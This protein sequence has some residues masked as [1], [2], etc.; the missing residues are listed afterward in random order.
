MILCD[1][2]GRPKNL[3]HD[4]WC[5]YSKEQI[6]EVRE[7][8]NS[9]LSSSK[10]V[11]LGFNKTLV[12]FSL[13]GIKRSLSES[14]KIAHKLYSDNFRHSEET[15][16]LLRKKTI[17]YQKCNP[18]KSTQ[19]KDRKISYP[20]RLFKQLLERN[21]LF[22]KYDIVREYS[23]FPYFIDF[24]FTNINL[25]VEIDGAQHWTDIKRIKSDEKKDN[26]LLSKN[27]RIYRIPAFLVINKIN[28]VEKTF[29]EYL[30]N[31][32]EQPKKKI[33]KNEIIEY[34]ELKKIQLET[35]QEI[36]RKRN[37]IQ[38]EIYQQ[39]KIDVNNFKHQKHYISKLS[40]LWNVSHTQ[41]RRF[42]IKHDLY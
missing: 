16:Q 29:L 6:Q 10:I 14:I 34:I 4:R 36:K 20:E 3:Q 25:A 17:E 33:F 35:K 9:G 42:L 27:W 5:V 37:N 22:E 28:E 11:K 15:K 2:C 13:R 24:A 38:Q 26:L 7:L 39:R 41:V 40:I 30:R 23:I 18:E 19:W 32:L 1:K 8:Y 31:I 21:K 12:C